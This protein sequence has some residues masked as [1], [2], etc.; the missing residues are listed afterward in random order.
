MLDRT[1]AGAAS[2]NPRPFKRA[3]FVAAIGGLLLG[4]R[5][6][7][8][9]APAT[10]RIPSPMFQVEPGWLKLPNQWVMGDPSSIAV[11]QH[12]HV[13]VLHR[14]RT[15]PNDKKDHAAPPVLEFE[16]SGAFIR[17]WGGPADGLEWPDTEHGI[18][19]DSK[20]HV[21][22]GG[23]NPI[24]Q[25]KLTTRSDDMLLEF[26]AN[27]RCLLQIGHRDRSR[28][29]ADTENVKEP[30]DVFVYEPTHELFVADGYGN[31]RVVVFDADKGMF[32]RMWGAFGNAPLD[33]PKPVPGAPVARVTDGPGPP[34]FGTV[35]AVRVSND[36]LVYVADRTNS[37]IQVFTLQGKYMTQVFVNRQG[38][39]AL[40]ASGLAFSPDSPQRFLYVADFG[41]NAVFVYNRKTLDLVS[42]FGQRGGEPGNF[43]NLH[44]IA[45][46]SKGNLYTAEVSPGSRI[47]KFV[48]KGIVTH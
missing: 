44:H 27:G 43:Q 20:D 22:I 6:L 2:R 11:D 15:V 17:G 21:W 24:A 31:R 29:N 26:D 35:H 32:K 18:Y 4:A 9:S 10:E 1:S 36:G 23:N 25:L 47:Q 3:V 19:V 48:F 34:Q 39:S 14:P 16:A 8:G 41:N 28:G 33:P 38:E 13:W 30:A 37:R 45:I 7:L 12:D 46:D 40:T 5:A 42:Q